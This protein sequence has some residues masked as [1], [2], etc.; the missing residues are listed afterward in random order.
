L[1][2][3][4]PP[5][6]LDPRSPPASAAAG[7]LP[8]DGPST[9]LTGTLV[10]EPA[11]ACTGPPPLSSRPAWQPAPGAEIA[12]RYRLLE[13]L[14]R[15]GH[16]EVW[17]ARDQVLGETV[18]I[19]LLSRAGAHRP[20]QARIEIALL[21]ALRMPG[22]ARLIDEGLE[23]GC[24]FVV[25]EVARGAPFPGP[26]DDG[27]RGPAPWAAVAPALMSLLEVLSRVHARGVVHRDLKPANVI[28]D[29]EGRATLLDFGISHWA[30]ANPRGEAGIVSGTP[31]Y[32]APEQCAGAS[33]DG[34]ADLYAVGVMVREAI[35]SPPPEIEQAIARLLALSPQDR[36]R[37]AEETMAAFAGSVPRTAATSIFQARSRRRR[38]AFTERSLRSLFTGPDRIFHLREDAAR[39]LWERTA[40]EPERLDAELTAWIRLGIARATLDGHAVEPSGL[41][42]LRHL[43]PA[44]P[45]ERDSIARAPLEEGLS[46][47]HLWLS[48]AIRP[49]SP[50]TL[51]DAMDA[52]APDM[53]ARCEKL[54]EEGLLRRVG[55]RF[56]VLLP[57]ATDDL[58]RPLASFHRALADALERGEE[59]RLYHLLAASELSAAADEAIALGRSLALTGDLAGARAA[60]CEG[61]SALRTGALDRPHLETAL[62][63]E[64]TKVAFSE[65]TP[66][67][68]DL[69]LYEILRVPGRGPETEKLE[70]LMRAATRV[71]GTISAEETAALPSF[72]DGELQRRRNHLR[73]LPFATRT[74]PR[75]MA[76]ALAETRRW[77]ELSGDRLARLCLAEGTAFL[78]YAQ[79][80]FDAAATAHLE[81][82]SLDPCATGK[83]ASLVNAASSLLEAFRHREAGTLARKA[84]K[85]AAAHRHFHSEARAE[86]V[87]RTARYRARESLRPDIELVSAVERLGVPG[88]HALVCLTE[89]AVAFRAGAAETARELATMAHRT[90]SELG[91]TW[92]ARFARCLAIRAGAET[93]AEEVAK[94]AE[95]S[96]QSP[97]PGAGLQAL[98]LLAAVQPQIGALFADAVP[99]LL[100]AI[101][102]PHRSLRMDVLSAD[103]AV[104][105]MRGSLS[106]RGV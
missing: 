65:A 97:V 10:T 33:V 70:A 62:L 45:A 32:M 82:A 8:P 90:W 40:G 30:E 39:K 68:H 17:T 38:G 37:S 43:R 88:I 87:Q 80:A 105:A 2:R 67:A 9:V 91:R 77:A 3:S 92:G 24:A 63:T 86:W 99:A 25:M 84:G 14:G 28:V 74:D 55:E 18:A 48:I 16:G 69:T 20:A 85:L 26:R 104:E 96:V 57:A 41:V 11:D 12:G 60:L 23:Q 71:P 4:V 35:E 49:L 13:P 53:S 46:Q 6:R 75:E 73:V 79:G 81:A 59:G 5:A 64:L 44:P 21:R 98:A 76:A 42:R 7:A 50:R 106:S 15:G 54:V 19:K 27:K 31:M 47:A 58:H 1:T 52:S 72:A 29:Q 34:R 103:E 102:V 95:A 61:L 89:A 66:M 93:S 51:A 22:V 56:E 100:S 83:I 94:L 36:F 101:P 78:R